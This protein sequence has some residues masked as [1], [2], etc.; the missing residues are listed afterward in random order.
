MRHAQ[1][2]FNEFFNRTRVDPGIVDPRITDQGR[3]QARQ[4]AAVL[5]TMPRIH[6]LL[7]SPFTRS[8]Q[9][10]SIIAERLGLKVT[11]E[12]LVRERGAF[13]C[14]IGTPRSALERDW[15]HLD[16]GDLPEVWWTAD[17]EALTSVSRR[18]AAFRAKALAMPDS[19]GTAVISHWGFILALTGRAMEN[20]MVVEFDPSEPGEA[21]PLG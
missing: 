14:D 12:P 5:Q 3:E 16:F 1:S 4:A 20:G 10:A 15:P 18:A 21:E 8:L 9:T 6:T 2:E 7:S 17:A 19:R 11:V 13:I